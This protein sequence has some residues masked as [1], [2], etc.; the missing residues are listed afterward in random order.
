MT[1]EFRQG[2]DRLPAVVMVC[3]H[4][5]PL[6]Q[7]GSGD[8][9]GLNVYVRHLAQG[10]A[11]LG[12]PVWVLTRQDAPGQVPVPLTA[13][14]DHPDDGSLAWVLPVPAGPP[15]PVDKDD[16]LP[17]IDAFAEAGLT[18]LERAGAWESGRPV[19]VH[20]H[21]WLS[22]L[23]GAKLARQLDAPLIHTMHTLAAVKLAQDPAAQES[24]AREPAEARLARTADLLVANTPVER[25]QLIELAGAPEDRIAVVPPGVDTHVFTP[26]GASDWPGKQAAVKLLFA[27]RIQSHK[28]PHVAIAALGGLRR[29]VKP[30]GSDGAA[31][32]VTLHLT[33]ARSGSEALDLVDLARRSGVEDWVTVSD[34][35]SPVQLAAAFRAADAV[36]MPSHSES[37]GLVA[38]EAQACGTPVLAHRV[39]GLV[40]AVEDGVTGR[41]LPDLEPATW[42]AA[43]N[44]ILEDLAPWTALGP[45]AARRAQLFGWDVMART[46]SGLYGRIS[47]PESPAHR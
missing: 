13:A 32:P 44:D 35:L 40:H 43:L 39:G 6:A 5:S 8:A 36:L 20:S 18:E 9:G 14:A 45:A 37:F 24:E 30:N 15:S 31:A 2:A 17:W 22:G 46:M 33:G 38:L 12:H 1:A 4:T 21:Y 7:P 28:G 26:E 16:L 29:T 19:V 23:T 47:G 27:G 3:L 25:Q 42:T 34:P 11:D 10:L 41:L